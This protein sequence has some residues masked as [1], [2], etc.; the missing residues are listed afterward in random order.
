MD[1]KKGKKFTVNFQ[2]KKNQRAEFRY[3]FFL[4]KL[5][6]SKKRP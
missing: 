4:L 1:Y 2:K 3:G 6:I 5:W